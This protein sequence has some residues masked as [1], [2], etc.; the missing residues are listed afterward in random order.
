MS[1]CLAGV[2]MNMLPIVKN[3]QIDIRILV[4]LD[5]LRVSP[6]QS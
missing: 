5:N 2:A 4:Y 6:K 1:E 3:A